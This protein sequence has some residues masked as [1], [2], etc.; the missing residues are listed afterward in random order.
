MHHLAGK[1]PPD[2]IS[3]F[4]LFSSSSVQIARALKSCLI[5]IANFQLNQGVQRQLFDV[6][7]EFPT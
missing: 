3:P 7:H 1:S 4:G 6:D 2:S 5:L